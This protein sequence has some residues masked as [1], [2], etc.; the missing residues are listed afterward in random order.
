MRCSFSRLATWCLGSGMGHGLWNK[1]Q[2]RGR[3]SDRR[4]RDGRKMGS[5]PRDS[6]VLSMAVGVT[7]RG[8]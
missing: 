8:L 4:A 3:R 5:H 7:L 1:E 6:P 2:D